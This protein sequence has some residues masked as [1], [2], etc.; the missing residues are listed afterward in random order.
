MFLIINSK[1]LKK[2][3]LKKN[4]QFFI[5]FSH[6]PFPIPHLLFLTLHSS[7]LI[8]HFLFSI[9][10][11]PFLIFHFPFPIPHSPFPIPYFLF[12]VSHSSFPILHSRRSGFVWVRSE[13]DDTHA[14]LSNLLFTS[15]NLSF[16]DW[17]DSGV[18]F[19]STCPK[20]VCLTEYFGMFGQIALD[21]ATSSRD[22]LSRAGS[23]SAGLKAHA[24]NLCMNFEGAFAR[25]RWH[26][27]SV[28]YFTRYK[29]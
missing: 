17:L 25:K 22:L 28:A 24:R 14:N 7:F 11:S 8:H 10:Y 27:A 1:S 5:L 29:R 3:N 21:H 12:L 13:S 26:T 23:Q 15:S 4:F 20:V 19:F 2:K 16:F 9:P 18:F 6:S